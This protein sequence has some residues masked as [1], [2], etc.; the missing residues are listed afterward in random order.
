MPQ[1]L[2][3][4]GVGDGGRGPVRGAS[5]A[6]ACGAALFLCF[7]VASRSAQN[8]RKG[9]GREEAWGRGGGRHGS[10]EPSTVA[11]PSAEPCAFGRLSSIHTRLPITAFTFL[12]LGSLPPPSSSLFGPYI[13]FRFPVS[14]TFSLHTHTHTNT[15]MT[16]HDRRGWRTVATSPK[17]CA[18]RSLT[19]RG[20]GFCSGT[21]EDEERGSQS[22]F[23]SVRSEKDKPHHGTPER[24]LA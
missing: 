20:T 4:L 9:S 2:L 8:L 3:S 12:Y 24:P 21:C 10:E 22:H 23:A 7:P 5:L 18:S 13:M 14:P 19:S 6:C 17:A 15:Y 16:T 1:G 11:G